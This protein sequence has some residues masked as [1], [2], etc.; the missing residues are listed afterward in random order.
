MSDVVY[1]CTTKS[2]FHVL[3]AID[4]NELLNK[5]KPAPE[6]DVTQFPPP[7]LAA[8]AMGTSNPFLR[9]K[10]SIAPTKLFIGNLLKSQEKKH[11]A[12]NREWKK[13]FQDPSLEV[14]I[15]RI[16]I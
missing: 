10:S 7:E 14:M 3:L 4:D 9:R 12:K 16:D 2:I 1:S 8:A 5:L 15:P 11:K 6:L 13:A